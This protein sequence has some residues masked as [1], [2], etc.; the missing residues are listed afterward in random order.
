MRVGARAGVCN[1]AEVGLAFLPDG[2][3]GIT[4]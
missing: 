2:P 3:H 1:E 4:R